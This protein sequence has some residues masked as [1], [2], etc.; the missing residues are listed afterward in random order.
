[1]DAGDAIR[2]A[3]LR[4]GLTQHALAARAGTSQATISA[5]ESGRKQ[6]SVETLERVLAAS[7]ARL[8]VVPGR[9]RV[10]RPTKRELARA[11]RTL[12]EVM[13]LAESLPVKHGRAL[14]YPR[15]VPR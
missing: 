3:R 5:Y 14:R 11:G 8:A 13:D 15:L 10:R 4:A 12:R 1:M 6:P 2:R 7:G 9:R